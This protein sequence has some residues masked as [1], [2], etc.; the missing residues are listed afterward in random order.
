MGAKGCVVWIDKEKSGEH[1][2]FM[3]H[4]LYTWCCDKLGTDTKMLTKVRP[5]KAMVFFQ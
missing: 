2:T 1:S 5:V 3:E 4:L